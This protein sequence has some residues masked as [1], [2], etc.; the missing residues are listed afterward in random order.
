MRPLSFDPYAAFPRMHHFGYRLM[1]DYTVRNSQLLR[2]RI[3]R[4]LNKYTDF[5]DEQQLL[6]PGQRRNRTLRRL[7]LRILD[8]KI[9]HAANSIRRHRLEAVYEGTK[10]RALL[11]QWMY[12][13]R[14]AEIRRAR[15][16]MLE[17]KIEERIERND[18]LELKWK[19]NRTAAMRLIVL[20]R[21]RQHGRYLRAHLKKCNEAR[22][23]AARHQ[24]I[25][26]LQPPPR[27]PPP[28]YWR[29]QMHT[30]WY[31]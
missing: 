10:A 30:R 29:M 4:I 25:L 11:R 15:L 17:I 28:A 1:L 12:R 21:V 23:A 16:S 20:K 7:Q 9:V 19:T 31:Q 2:D 22:R 27:P 26:A 6:A 18:A 14:A 13:R 5:A 3:S 24:H 8:Y